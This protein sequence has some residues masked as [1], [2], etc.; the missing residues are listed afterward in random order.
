MP[1]RSRLSVR[2]SSGARNFGNIAAATPRTRD[3]FLRDR[4][5]RPRRGSVFFAASSV[6]F[7][8]AVIGVVTEMVAVMVERGGATGK[9]KSIA[10]TN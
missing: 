5:S 3:N 10:T 2:T 1:T 8:T 9:L 7:V 4:E 6:F